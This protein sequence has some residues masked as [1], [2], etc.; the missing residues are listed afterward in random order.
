MFSPPK[1]EFLQQPLAEGKRSR[2]RFSIA[3]LLEKE[4]TRITP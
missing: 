2:F 4:D 3:N 1:A